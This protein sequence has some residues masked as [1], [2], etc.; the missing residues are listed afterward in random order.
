MTLVED[1]LLKKKKVNWSRESQSKKQRRIE[2][3][4]PRTL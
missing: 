2:W 1:F 4:R 3:K